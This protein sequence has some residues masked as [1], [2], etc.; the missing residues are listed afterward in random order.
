MKGIFSKPVANKAAGFSLVELMIVVSI[1]GILAALAVPRFTKF[2]AKARQSE[3]RTNLSMVYTL[4]MSNHSENDTYVAFS[5]TV[6]STACN[7]TALGFQVDPCGSKIRYN[8]STSGISA[9][10]FTA[11][12]TS[13]ANVIVPGCATLDVWTINQNKLL[14]NGTNAVA[15]CS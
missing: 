10:E 4:Q 6:T 7:E 1:I 14:A 13:R 2:Q 11:T 12:A 3:A 15:S 8:Y 5:R 9:T